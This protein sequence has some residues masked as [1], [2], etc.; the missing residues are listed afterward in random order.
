[1]QYDRQSFLSTASLGF[2]LV[3]LVGLVMTPACVIGYSPIGGDETEDSSGGA[4]AGT[5][6]DSTDSSDTDSSTT[7]D[8]DASDDDP[9]TSTEGVDTDTDTGDSDTGGGCEEPVP[10]EHVYE[11]SLTSNGGPPPTQVI[12]ELCTV[13][14][15]AGDDQVVWT[16]DCLNQDLVLEVSGA[17][18][19]TAVGSSGEQ[20]HVWMRSV[21]GSI[22]FPGAVWLRA[23]FPDSDASLFMVK[24]DTVGLSGVEN[25]F[26]APWGM[27]VSE[28]CGPFSDGCATVDLEQMRVEFQGQKLEV[29]SGAHGSVSVGDSELSLWLDRAEDILDLDEACDPTPDFFLTKRYFMVSRGPLVEGDV[30]DPGLLDP[31]GTGLHCCYPCGIMGCDFLCTPEDPNSMEC[32]PPPP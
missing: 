29:W 5:T 19:L 24:G 4:D 8:S 27:A 11:W 7:S 10:G 21:E 2:G 25:Y 3:G 28:T 17:A 6:G 20:A 22:P 26:P 15:V 32:P 9:D 14:V 1:M 18:G 13:D 16:F 30:C 23:D 31:C 12:D